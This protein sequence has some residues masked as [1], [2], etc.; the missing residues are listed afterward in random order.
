[1]HD[2]LEKLK[3]IPHASF[4]YATVGDVLYA[5]TWKKEDWQDWLPGFPDIGYSRNIISLDPL[6]CIMLQWAPGA[7]S[8]VHYH[9]GFWGYVVVLE[10]TC[11]NV[12]Y[13]LNNQV[14]S[15]E[16]TT[17]V[18]EQG[19]L[20]EPDNI[21]HKIVNA[22]N[23]SPLITLHFYAPAL[24]DLNGLRIYDL[25]EGRIGILNSRA[26]SA[27]WQ[28]PVEHFQKIDANAFRFQKPD[29]DNA[30]SHI[31]RPLIPKPERN[32]IAAM[33]A[34]YYDDQAMIYDYMDQAYESRKQYINGINNRIAHFL[35]N[36]GTR[37]EQMLALACGTGRRAMEIRDKT[38]L[39]YHLTGLDISKNMCEV[40]EDRDMDIVHADWSDFENVLKGTYDAATFLN[41]F[42]HIS[43]S[44]ERLSILRRIREMMAPD[45]PLF[46]DVFHLN[47]A[48]EWGPI[49]VNLHESLRLHQFG[50]E[51]GDVFYS[52]NRHNKLAFLHY[53]KP[54]EI[55]NLLRQAGFSII[56][57]EY[58]GYADNPGETVRNGNGNIFITAVAAK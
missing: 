28:E 20:P 3:D 46:L 35:L 47:D 4:S 27:S 57:M 58:V 51:E 2:V 34:G 26:K 19:I 12:A 29:E 40:A 41:A 56:N 31:V 36:A 17:I 52:R 8:A 48:T 37:P 5:A 55:S 23:T 33:L 10:G 30:P 18:H 50:Y 49:I 38:G 13:D 16:F 22:S 25:Q 44:Q 9:K 14:M 11:A 54:D 21:I 39:S 43:N 7:E 15:Q 42:G 6:E 32:E 1:M 24:T 53:F 45:A